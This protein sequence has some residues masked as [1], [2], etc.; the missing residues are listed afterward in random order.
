MTTNKFERL[1]ASDNGTQV[2]VKP[3]N[4]TYS[5]YHRLRVEMTLDKLREI[6][7]SKIVE[8]G[9]HPWTMTSAFVDDPAFTVCATVSAEEVTNWPDDI[10]VTTSSY[11]L[12]T[13][14]GNKATFVN[15]SAN[16]ERTLFDI[17]E[18]PDTVVAAEIIEHLTRSPHVML[19]NIN[20][21][22]PLGGKLF[23]TTPNAAQFSNPFRL[24]SP[25]AAYRC[26]T[27]E[28]HSYLFTLEGLTDI[29]SLCGFKIKEAGYWDVIKRQGPSAIY[30][31]L[32]HVPLRYFRQKFKK[33]LFV[34]A[35]KDRTV[36]E[37][38]RCPLV[39]DARGNW[40]HI[41]PR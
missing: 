37:L 36:T 32:S 23:I 17:N 40:E 22:L 30:G 26:N 9:S 20:R 8:L 33:T 21:W 19:L 6:G 11:E 24:Q 35:E 25:T 1:S 4:E 7:A 27:Y 16:L 2:S 28:R 12:K 3:I 5:N 14:K 39:Y 38:E 34:V 31:W 29:V 13:T 18:K 41:R 10:G 15:Y